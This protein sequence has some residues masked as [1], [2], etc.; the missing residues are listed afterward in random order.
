[1]FYGK[2]T[3]ITISIMTSCIRESRE[4]KTILF[5]SL[6]YLFT[7]AL[8]FNWIVLHNIIIIQS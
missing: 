7:I 2:L 5:T 6:V 3:F 1:M 4:D 8:T